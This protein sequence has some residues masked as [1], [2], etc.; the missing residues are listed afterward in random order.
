MA[1]KRGPGVKGGLHIM[2]DSGN[3]TVIWRGWRGGKQWQGGQ[4]GWGGGI[5]GREGE[6]GGRGLRLRSTRRRRRKLG[7]SEE[8]PDLCRRGRE[9]LIEIL[10]LH[11]FVP[12][13]WIEKLIPYST[14]YTFYPISM[15]GSFDPQLIS[16]NNNIVDIK[17]WSFQYSNIPINYDDHTQ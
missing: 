15:T 17:I 7:G 8:T 6:I 9:K 11:V 5:R 3:Y 10:T 2:R 13:D 4:R 16:T 1:V 12:R 14:I